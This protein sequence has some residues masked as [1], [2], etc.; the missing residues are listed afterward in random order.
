MHFAGEAQSRGEFVF[1]GGDSLLPLTE[2]GTTRRDCWVPSPVRPLACLTQM[3]EGASGMAHRLQPQQIN[4]RQPFIASN[5]KVKEHYYGTMVP[6]LPHEKVRPDSP[7]RHRPNCHSL[8]GVGSGSSNTNSP[9]TALLQ[10]APESLLGCDR[11][12][13]GHEIATSCVLS[14]TQMCNARL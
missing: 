5:T 6:L 4:D 11:L 14:D 3:V 9:R 10:S 8:I 1:P 2:P 7:A 12:Q 13:P